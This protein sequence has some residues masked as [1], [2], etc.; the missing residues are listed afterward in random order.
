M[1]EITVPVH[2]LF[3]DEEQPLCVY[4]ILSYASA[5]IYQELGKLV[6]DQDIP[7]GERL[8]SAADVVVRMVDTL[9]LMND[10]E[11]CF[12]CERDQE[13]EEEGPNG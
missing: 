13:A 10:A 3:E 6:F 4:H 7:A 9:A 8:L 5:G 11:P 12:W 2:I 1:K